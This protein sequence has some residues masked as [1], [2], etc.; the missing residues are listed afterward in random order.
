MFYEH[1]RRNKGVP[2]EASSRI[3]FVIRYPGKIKAEKVI[4]KAY[5]NTDFAPTIL[6][7]MSIK[8]DAKFHG[9]DTSADFTSKD[10]IVDGNRIVHFAQCDGWWAA[11]TDGRYKLI[12]DKKESPWLI[13]MKEDPFELKNCYNDADKRTI[14]QKMQ[15]ELMK[16]LQEFKGTGLNK[17]QGY[18][19]K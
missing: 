12:I 1:K 3:P 8:T 17:K 6:S 7:L 10:K 9:E 18:I 13:D 2:Y 16:Q 19:L 11:A 4:N 14:A 15:I 5:V